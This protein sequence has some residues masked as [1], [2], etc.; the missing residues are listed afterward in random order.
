MKSKTMKFFAQSLLFIASVI[1]L[2]PQ[3]GMAMGDKVGEFTLPVEVHW[4]E[5]ILPPGAYTISAN[6]QIS[7]S[8]MCV[9]KVGSPTVGYFIPAM[10][11]ETIPSSSA[12]TELVL[13]EKDGTVYVKVLQ[14][15][16]EGLE[17]HYAAPKPK[18]SSR[19]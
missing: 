5:V 12:K 3:A 15:N 9:Y 8:M 1:A 4:G 16:G 17:F 11:Q 18:K 7:S 10:A 19:L 2:A 14:M 6:T 13:G